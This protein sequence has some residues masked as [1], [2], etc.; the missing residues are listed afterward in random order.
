[1]KTGYHPTV[2]GAV[3][4]KGPFV[5]PILREF[6]S[7]YCIQNIKKLKPSTLSRWFCCTYILVER[8][9]LIAFPLMNSGTE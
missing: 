2:M 9:V 3:F 5:H 7:L 6:L 4:D 1:M 8:H